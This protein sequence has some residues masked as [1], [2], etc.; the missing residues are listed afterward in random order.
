MALA[1]FDQAEVEAGEL[2]GRH[3]EL[4][5]ARHLLETVQR[6]AAA[7]RAERRSRLYAQIK[8]FAD[9]KQWRHALDTA[10]RLVAAHPECPEAK[11]ADAMMS[12]LRENA[13]IEQ[14]R[15]MRDRLTD[16]VRRRRFAEALE[17]ARDVI[18]QFP[19]SQAAIELQSQ[20]PRLVELAAS[21][22]GH[23]R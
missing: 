5:E 7:F 21:G 16:M 13:K 12:T 20:L 19:D 23:A 2:A 9:A 4:A 3:P 18:D 17:I 6:E 1:R 10:Q 8:R 11:E 15:E 22:Q 14:V